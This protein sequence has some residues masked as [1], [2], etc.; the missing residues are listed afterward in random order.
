MSFSVGRYSHT[1]I[2]GFLPLNIILWILLV[3]IGL[4]FGERPFGFRM[5]HAC[6]SFIVWKR[7]YFFTVN[8]KAILLLYFISEVALQLVLGTRWIQILIDTEQNLIFAKA[9]FKLYLHCRYSSAKLPFPPIKWSCSDL[10]RR[11]WIVWLNYL[12]T[13]NRYE[14]KV[15]QLTLTDFCVAQ[16]PITSKYF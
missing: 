9:L 10:R 8:I 3:R 12:F 1:T 11:L 16:G 15:E 2:F 7:L 4:H 6:L 13:Q 14:A 5:I